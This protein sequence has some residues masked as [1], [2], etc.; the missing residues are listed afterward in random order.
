MAN[1]SSK[2]PTSDLEAAKPADPQAA[3]GSMAGL[4]TFWIEA[5][6]DIGAEVAG[7]IA[8]RIKEDV[9]TQYA[10][11][12]CKNAADLQH[13][14]YEFVQKAVEQYQAETGKLLQMGTD[15]FAA[16]AGRN[17]SRG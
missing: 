7:F 10:I 1:I 8:E 13:I 6:S 5:I 16:Q 9:K 12:H 11:L 14:Q 15:A 2:Q 17:T 4:G 3:L